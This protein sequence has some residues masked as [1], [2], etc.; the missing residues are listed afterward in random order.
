MKARTGGSDDLRAPLRPVLDDD[1][2]R[3][4]AEAQRRETVQRVP[5]LGRGRAEKDERCG[6][7]PCPAR[8]IV[9]PADH[10]AVEQS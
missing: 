7:V 10:G 4:R 9:K 3:V 6:Q 1:G 5:S 2:G 8:E